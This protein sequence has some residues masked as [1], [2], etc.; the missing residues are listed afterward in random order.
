[1][2][3]LNPAPSDD[4]QNDKISDIDE[5]TTPKLRE[6]IQVVHKKNDPDENVRTLEFTRYGSKFYVKEPVNEEGI[7]GIR[8]EAHIAATIDKFPRLANV[9]CQFRFLSSGTLVSKG[10]PGVPVYRLPA[11]VK[12]SDQFH[13][14]LKRV[15]KLFKRHY[16]A[17][18]DFHG[19][20]MFYDV[21]SERLWVIDVG[22]S[23]FKHDCDFTQSTW[24]TMTPPYFRVGRDKVKHFEFV[25]RLDTVLS[26]H[27]VATAF[28]EVKAVDGDDEEEDAD[29]DADVMKKLE[30][31]IETNYGWTIRFDDHDFY[32]F[33]QRIVSA[34]VESMR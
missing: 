1:M 29:D 11:E 5:I 34:I 4:K 7:E 6:Q 19:N 24:I 31:L 22:Q 17:H 23:Q 13:T 2:N 25:Q 16:F 20:N 12:R 21:D 18:G 26:W 9:F 32:G 33:H 8:R 14:E 28:A 10:V 27:Q 30:E 3:K 15:L